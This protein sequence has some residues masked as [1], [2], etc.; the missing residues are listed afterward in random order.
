MNTPVTNTQALLFSLIG[1]IIMIGGFMAFLLRN[2]RIKG[3]NP[4]APEPIEPRAMVQQQTVQRSQKTDLTGSPPRNETA[5]S[6]PITPPRTLG[7]A[8]VMH[9]LQTAVHVMIVG[10]QNS[11]KSTTANAVLVGRVQAGE[12]ILIL[13]PHAAPSDWHGIKAIGFGRDFPAIEQMMLSLIDEL[14]RRYEQRAQQPDY[15]PQPLTCFVDEWPAISDNSPKVAPLFMR[16]LVQEG[17][18]VGLR[19]VILT[20]SDRV[21]S[22]GL[23]GKGDVRSNFCPLLLGAKAVE[24]CP[25]AAHLQRAGAIE[26]GG[27]WCSASVDGM[28]RMAQTPLPVVNVWPPEQPIVKDKRLVGEAYSDLSGANTA[29]IGTGSLLSG[30]DTIKGD[31]PL[32][33]LVPMDS[34]NEV[35]D[36]RNQVEPVSNEQKKEPLATAAPEPLDDLSVAIRAM[37]AAGFSR[38]KILILLTIPGNRQEGLKRIKV[39]LGEVES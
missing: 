15:A 8:A 13:D 37:I 29:I 30:G 1:S 34:R 24:K 32:L 4:N 3:Y 21:E 31:A 2:Q 12:Q 35:L 6:L 27:V 16:Q 7:I 22:L 20:Q 36:F 26:H 18:K 5:P 14:T 10:E 23:A 11:G 19:L 38:N 28:A 9:K 25:D 17:R 33:P 39:A